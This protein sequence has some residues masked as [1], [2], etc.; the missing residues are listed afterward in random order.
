MPIGLPKKKR[1]VT[2]QEYYIGKTI[3]LITLKYDTPNSVQD[4]FKSF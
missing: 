4:S 1:Y 3:G 2:N